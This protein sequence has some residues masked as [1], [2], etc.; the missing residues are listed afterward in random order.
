MIFIKLKKS[1]KGQIYVSAYSSWKSLN[2]IPPLK[3]AYNSI[4]ELTAE[5]LEGIEFED[6][7]YK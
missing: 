2:N 3:E 5:K 7:N 4:Y 1:E 6:L